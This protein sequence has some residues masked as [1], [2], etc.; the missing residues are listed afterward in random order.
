MPCCH[1]SSK[2]FGIFYFTKI[3][4]IAI[5]FMLAK[6]MDFYLALGILNLIGIIIQ[7]FDFETDFKFVLKGKCSDVL[8][9]LTFINCIYQAFN[10]ILDFSQEYTVHRYV[11][12]YNGH[13]E[14]HSTSDAPCRCYCSI[15]MFLFLSIFTS[16]GIFL[17]LLARILLMI[18]DL[19]YY[20]YSN[21]KGIEIYS[22]KQT[23]DEIADKNKAWF[24]TVQINKNNKDDPNNYLPSEAAA[25][26]QIFINSSK[27]FTRLKT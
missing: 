21:Y 20:I 11:V 27:S 1:I 24:Q 15:L 23:Y 4:G 2:F 16:F 6:N 26:L 18:N 17:Y 25:F 19:G 3:V 12:F 13:A 10:R 8:I 5:C 7:F 9:W 14:V 22:M